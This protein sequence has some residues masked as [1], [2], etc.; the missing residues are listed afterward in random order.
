MARW[1][2]SLAFFTPFFLGLG[3]L[4]LNSFPLFFFRPR[5]SGSVTLKGFEVSL[6]AF[7]LFSRFSFGGVSGDSGH[8]GLFCVFEG[9]SLGVY[10]GQTSVFSSSRFLNP[11]VCGATHLVFLAAS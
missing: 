11:F 4:F 2:F 6:A 5:F 9:L 8:S 3:P 1:D 7:K 10:T